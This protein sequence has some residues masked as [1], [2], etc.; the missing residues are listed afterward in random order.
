MTLIFH[1]W[2]HFPLEGGH[3]HFPL[4]GGTSVIAYINTCLYANIYI[5]LYAYIWICLYANIY[6]CLYAY[7]RMFDC[8]NSWFDSCAKVMCDKNATDSIH[9]MFFLCV[10]FLQ[11]DIFT[12][13]LSSG[14]IL[15]TLSYSFKFFVH[16]SFPG[17]WA[18][19]KLTWVCANVMANELCKN[20]SRYAQNA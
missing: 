17:F 1:R 16:D 18:M 20:W 11:R 8:N 10:T 5:C 2:G 9:Q 4:E 15:L 19:Q 14:K 6:I 13:N 3:G 12:T 7:I